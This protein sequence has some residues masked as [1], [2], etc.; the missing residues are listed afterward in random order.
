LLEAGVV[1]WGDADSEIQLPASHTEQEC[2]YKIGVSGTAGV[3]LV[4]MVVTQ[5]PVSIS[6]FVKQHGEAGAKYYLH[7]SQR[8]VELQRALATR[9]APETLRNHGSVCV[10][11]PNHAEQLEQDFLLYHK[12]GCQVRLLNQQQ[13]E[14]YHGQAAGFVRGIEFPRDCIVHSAE[15]SKALLRAAQ[16]TGL[17]QVRERCP[18]VRDVQDIAA[19]N[20]QPAHALVLLSDG[21]ALRCKHAVLATGGLYIP[22][23]LRGVLRPCWSYFSY[24][25][26]DKVLHPKPQPNSPNFFTFDFS[27]DWCVTDGEVRISGEDHFSALKPPR[28]RDRCGRLAG[29]LRQ[30]YPG[31]QKAPLLRTHYGIYSDT[32]DALPIVG[33]RHS[34]SSVCY[35]L[36]CNA[37]GQSILSYCAS[38]M[39][40]V[41]GVA[42]RS[43]MA[44]A[45][46]QLLDLISPVR[47]AARNRL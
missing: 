21:V 19:S 41:L 31:L 7:M 33:L 32:P 47:F 16:K 2:T 11:F 13:V 3:G 35:L 40:V 29:W 17:L 26:P 24:L 34:G 14:E 12:M 45:D 10:A 28:W 6:E 44:A 37:W 38:L 18:R 25:T 46:L 1:G 39:P 42:D 30:R 36:G 27:H 4:K 43:K 9:F 15:F 22:Q 20:A 23:D 5:P 8:G